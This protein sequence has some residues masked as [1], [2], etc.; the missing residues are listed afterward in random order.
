MTRIEEVFLQRNKLVNIIFWFL[1]AISCTVVIVQF[2]VTSLINAVGFVVIS[3]AIYIANKREK[4]IKVTPYVLMIFMLAVSIGNTDSGMFLQIA[5]VGVIFM[6]MYPNYLI[7]LIYSSIVFTFVMVDV[8]GRDLLHGGDQLLLEASSSII[9][10]LFTFTAAVVVARLNQKLFLQ[11]EERTVQAISVNVQV[12]RLFE[13]IR[14]SAALLAD[15][16]TNLRDNVE[17]TGK[18]TKEVTIGFSEVAKGMES[19]TA[20]VVDISE[21]VSQTEIN[22]SDVADRAVEMNKL[23]G[24]NASFTEKG[25]EQIDSLSEQINQVD[26]NI[27]ELAEFMNNLNDQSNQIESMLARVTAIAAQT[28][29]LALNSAIEAARAGEHGRGFAVVSNEVKKLAESSRGAAEDIG[30]IVRKIGAS[31]RSLTDQIY[32]SKAAIHRSKNSAAFSRELL[33]QISSNTKDV[34]SQSS[35]VENKTLLLRQ[36]AGTIVEEINSISSVT[37][38]TSASVEQILA[39]M[40]EQ[41]QMVD[42]IVISFQKLDG[43]IIQLKLLMKEGN[44]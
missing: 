17:I 26:S 9:I 25:Y 44:Q 33:E 29:L 32:F 8:V 36:A 1:A 6:M 38:Q 7:T 16:S 27:G 5:M 42:N 24:D 14:N 3:C 22:I 13:E 20:S 12:N 30:E 4:F 40:E 31:C 21:S 39:S 41:Q 43:L 15:F 2:S 11:A 23:S 35:Q 37:E 19:Q 28:N 18:L 34:V 10:P